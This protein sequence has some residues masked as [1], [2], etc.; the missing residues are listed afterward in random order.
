[1]EVENLSLPITEA[2]LQNKMIFHTK[3]PSVWNMCQGERSRPGGILVSDIS[4]FRWMGGC[5][6]FLIWRIS[7]LYRKMGLT[8]ALLMDL[9]G[10]ATSVMAT[11]ARHF[12]LWPMDSNDQSLDHSTCSKWHNTP[13]KCL[14]SAAAFLA[15]SSDFLVNQKAQDI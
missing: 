1:M 12:V 15:P 5:R 8:G 2:G 13:P 14:H 7:S 3:G 4:Q 10:N 11:R 6:F 9:P